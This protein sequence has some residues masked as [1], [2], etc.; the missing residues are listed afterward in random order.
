VG[1][2]RMIEILENIISIEERADE[3]PLI[4]IKKKFTTDF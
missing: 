1:S 4:D 2:K 3:K